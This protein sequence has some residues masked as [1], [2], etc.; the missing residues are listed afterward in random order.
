MHVFAL[1]L[2][3]VLEHQFILWIQATPS[4]E[5]IKEVVFGMGGMKAPGPDD[6]HAIFL[7]KE[8]D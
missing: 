4:D 1:V 8:L 6:I 2:I 3:P 7:S 5:E